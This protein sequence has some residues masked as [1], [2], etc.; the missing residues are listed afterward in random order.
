M[1]RSFR[2]LSLTAGACALAVVCTPPAQGSTI[3]VD[4]NFADG[5]R[6]ATGTLDPLDSNWWTSSSSSGDEIAVGSLGLVTGSSGRGIHTVFAP[7]TLSVGESIKV[8]FDFTT[9]ATIGTNKGTSVRIGLFD[10]LGRALDED[11]SA[12]SSSP[13]AVYDILPGYITTLD[14]GTGSED[15]NFREHNTTGTGSGRLMATTSNFDSIGSGGDPYTFAADTD[16]TGMFTLTKVS[17]SDMQ[18]D[19]SLSNA[20]GVLSSYS[21]TDDSLT[22]DTFSF[23]GV[24]VN[25]GVFGSSNSAGD[26]D[27]GI[28]FTNVT[29]EVIPE[30]STA[31]LGMAGGL[32]LLKRRKA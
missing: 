11:I 21:D 12:S 4:D 25:S 7:Q 23:F 24:H 32:M 5:D 10:G 2:H 9:P 26:P 16:Y 1:N 29:I 19:F 31:L 14:V 22:A 28:D 18:L 27:N 17:A 13:N 20:T 8:T 3:I 30:P 6:A 15:I